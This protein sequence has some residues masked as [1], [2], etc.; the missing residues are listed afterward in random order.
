MSLLSEWKAPRS[1]K[2]IPTEQEDD[3]DVE[4]KFLDD[5]SIDPSTRSNSEDGELRWPLKPN[6]IRSH[7]IS[8]SFLF[9]NLVLLITSLFVNRSFLWDKNYCIRETSYYCENIPARM[10]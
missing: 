2:R 10:L 6:T 1:W 3:L 4:K 7:K 5:N 8:L 9:I